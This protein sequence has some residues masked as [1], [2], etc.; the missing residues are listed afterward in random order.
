MRGDLRRFGRRKGDLGGLG[1]L[2]RD[3]R[4]RFRL[5]RRR[6]RAPGQE[7][8]YIAQ[9]AQRAQLLRTDGGGSGKPLLQRG[10]DLD[11]FDRVYAQIRVH[12]HV[13]LQHIHRVA[14]L[15]ADHGEEFRGDVDSCRPRRCGRGRSGSGCGGRGGRGGA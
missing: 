8:G 6:F 4:D 9:G 13:E 15:V 12:S 1:C 5:G 2:S 10:E 11:P 14:G 7:N 3:R